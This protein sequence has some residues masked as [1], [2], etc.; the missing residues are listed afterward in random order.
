MI[1]DVSLYQVPMVHDLIHGICRKMGKWEEVVV[2]SSPAGLRIG[3][4]ELS[5]H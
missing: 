5:M 1:R 2:G 3:G 4:T